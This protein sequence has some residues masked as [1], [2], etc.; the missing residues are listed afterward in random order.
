MANKARSFAR[1]PPDLGNVSVSV[2]QGMERVL[3]SL[4]D[5]S[6]A[7]VPDMHVGSALEAFGFSFWTWLRSWRCKLKNE[8]LSRFFRKRALCFYYLFRVSSPTEI[9]S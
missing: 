7:Q 4:L 2:D 6:T 5:G 3:V 9:L 8:C 1:L